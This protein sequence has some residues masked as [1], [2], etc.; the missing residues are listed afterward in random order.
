MADT[1]NVSAGGNLLDELRAS[2]PWIDQIGLSTEFFQEL[3]A[4]AASGAE[5]ITRLR[6][7]PQYRARFQGL[8][9]DDGSVRMTE[10]DYLRTEQQYR[11]LLSQYGMPTEAKNVAKFFQGDVDPNELKD[12]LD[13]Y[14][15]VKDS[16]Q[17][18]KDAFYVYAGMRLSDDDLY[19]AT[20]DPQA[21]QGL[22]DEYSRV[23][24]SST[25]DYTTWIT[26]ATEVGL[27]R[28]SKA[29]T[30]AQ[31]SGALTGQAVQT[32]MRTDPSFARTIMD[33][34]Y[35]GG[36]PGADPGLSL[37]ELLSSFEYAAVGAAASNA[38]LALPSLDRIKEIRSAGVDRAKAMSG[39]QQFAE[40]QGVYDSAVRRAGVDGFGQ[41]QFEKAAFLGDA[42]QSATLQRALAR[43]TAAGSESGTFRF[44]MGRDGRLVQQGLTNRQ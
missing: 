22:A 44:D 40:N 10:A 28:A 8:W 39:Y 38:G 11:T 34:L 4:T 26:R 12:R 1:T 9:R 23:V 42:S 21:R 29:L 16:G 5:I 6:Q 36:S 43:E 3:A 15:R 25:F 17:D 19:K 33:A 27:D 18:V 31:R 41:G 13:V 2:F 20:V 37:Q 14:Q 32:V 35:T 30:D 7:Q 24:S